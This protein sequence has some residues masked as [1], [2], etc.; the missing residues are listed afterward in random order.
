MAYSI[1]LEVPF[2]GGAIISLCVMVVGWVMQLLF[3]LTAS[4]IF[5][6]MS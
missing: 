2:S 6:M 5:K 4:T 1:A 3:G